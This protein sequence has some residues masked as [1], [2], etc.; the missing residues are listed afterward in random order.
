MNR[1]HCLA[2]SLHRLPVLPSALVHL[3][4]QSFSYLA[5]D[6]ECF[7]NF[8]T[9][10]PTF[11]VHIDIVDKDAWFGELPSAL[12]SLQNTLEAADE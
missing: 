4:S 7:Y 8:P 3:T 5:R 12:G 6:S 2:V 11:I 9:R 1:Q 10:G